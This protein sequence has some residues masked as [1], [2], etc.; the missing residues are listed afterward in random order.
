MVGLVDGLHDVALED[1]RRTEVIYEMKDATQKKHA[2]S[3]RLL[4]GGQAQ[5]AAP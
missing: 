4:L 2:F 5:R 3:F 1:Q